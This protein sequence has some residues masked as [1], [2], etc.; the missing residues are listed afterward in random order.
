MTDDT[1]PLF[2]SRDEAAAYVG[3]GPDVFAA[4]V[5][6]GLWPDPVRRGAKGGKLTWFRP[7]L[8]EAAH[9]L[10]RHRP[11]APPSPE[12][13]PAAANTTTEADQKI[14][15]RIRAQSKDRAQHRH[16]RAA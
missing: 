9:A 15:E 16:P 4:E 5:A 10:A 11:A 1:R 6:A 8:V 3:V 2:L 7:A 13:P 14:V 12:P